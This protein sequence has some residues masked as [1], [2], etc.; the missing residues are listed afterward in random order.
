MAA[1][2]P[3]SPAPGLVPVCLRAPSGRT[4]IYYLP[5]GHAAALRSE[6]PKAEDAGQTT[7]KAEAPAEQDPSDVAD[8]HEELEDAR[9][10]TPQWPFVE[11]D[12]EEP[13]LQ[14]A[15]VPNMAEP[16]H[17]EPMQPWPVA[18]PWPTEVQQ[19]D[20]EQRLQL[21]M[22]QQMRMQS[23]QQYQPHQPTQHP[24]QPFQ[25]PQAHQPQSCDSYDAHPVTSEE[26]PPKNF[27]LQALTEA[28]DR[29]EVDMLTGGRSRASD[30]VTDAMRQCG[31]EVNDYILGDANRGSGGSIN[32]ALKAA[33]EALNK[34]M[35]SSK[36]KGP[37]P[38]E[39]DRSLATA[40]GL[41]VNPA[42]RRKAPKQE[43]DHAPSAAGRSS[44]APSITRKAVECSQP[45]GLDS[46]SQA[47][48]AFAE[49]MRASETARF[50]EGYPPY[51][52]PRQPSARERDLQEKSRA[53]VLDL[54]LDEAAAEEAKNEEIEE[55]SEDIAGFGFGLADALGLEVSTPPWARKLRPEQPE[56]PEHPHRSRA[57][58]VTTSKHEPEQP[59]MPP[60]MAPPGPSER[61]SPGS[62]VQEVKE[63]ELDAA[64]AYSE[65][66]RE[67]AAAALPAQLQARTSEDWK[68]SSLERLDSPPSQMYIIPGL[69][70]RRLESMSRDLSRGCVRMPRSNSRPKVPPIERRPLQKRD[71]L[72]DFVLA[73]ADPARSTTP[74]FNRGPSMKGQAMSTC[75]SQFPDRKQL[76]PR[77]QKQAQPTVA[78]LPPLSKKKRYLWQ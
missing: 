65:V 53:L 55:I 59:P 12:H 14:E 75:Y 15:K 10:E 5:P 7:A 19:F 47:F 58:G 35:E 50:E 76:T 23:F 18:G 13:E 71:N 45:S 49:Q 20:Y 40:L 74:R 2:P 70:R 43:E 69:D 52:P 32:F 56:Q 3:T 26:E 41:T 68:H 72:V 38:E 29:A 11:T 28:L 22:I 61:F 16:V 46:Q 36:P 25:L 34:A 77:R 1:A 54:D 51:R 78:S 30:D 60:M 24:F 62:S 9:P 73:D 31:F 27:A 39:F 4:A 64:K 42:G 66:A 21:Q 67:A 17:A 44:R 63:P 33:G 37:E 6:P 8:V 48:D 57:E